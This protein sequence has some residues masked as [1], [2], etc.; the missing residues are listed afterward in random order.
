MGPRPPR[1]AALSE[2]EHEVLALAGRGLTDREI[3]ARLTI[4]G[5]T[6]STHLGH[7]YRKLGV[8]NR[9]DAIAL[10]GDPATSVDL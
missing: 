7:V 2:R 5:R 4:G 6:A 1:L 8:T 9:H 3:A 10:L